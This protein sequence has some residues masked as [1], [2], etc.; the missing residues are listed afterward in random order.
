MRALRRGGGSSAAWRD[1]ALFFLL[2]G[3]EVVT[4]AAMMN[5]TSLR[6]VS[7]PVG[8]WSVERASS[9]PGRVVLR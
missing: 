4:N 3:G 5:A 6:R 8:Q 2:G 7:V 9:S 1:G